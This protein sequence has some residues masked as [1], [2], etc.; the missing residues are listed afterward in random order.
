MQKGPYG[1][2]VQFEQRSVLLAMHLDGVLRFFALGVQFCFSEESVLAVI[3]SNTH[4][5]SGVQCAKVG[6]CTFTDLWVARYY[7]QVLLVLIDRVE[8]ITHAR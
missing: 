2:L 4:A 5:C 6:L 1:A 7:L 3:V 8:L